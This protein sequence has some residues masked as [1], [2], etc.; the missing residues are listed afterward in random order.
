MKYGHDSIAAMQTG[1]ELRY[2]YLR[3]PKAQNFNGN[4]PICQKE[5]L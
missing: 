5:R 4:Y 3:F 2:I 1:A